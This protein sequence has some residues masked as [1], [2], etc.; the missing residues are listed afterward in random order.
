MASPVIA[1]SDLLGRARDLA[2]RS[3]ACALIG[4][5]AVSART[6]P[7]STRDVDLAVAVGSDAE[8]EGLLAVLGF[9]A[10][11]ARPQRGLR[12]PQ[13]GLSAA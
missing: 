8:A 9:S 3:A 6:E 4:G 12:T 1:L 10:A 2:A 7:R 5:I 11:S 13:G